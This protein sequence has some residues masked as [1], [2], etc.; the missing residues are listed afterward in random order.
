MVFFTTALLWFHYTSL[1]YNAGQFYI[2]WFVKIIMGFL[3]PLLDQKFNSNPI[4]LSAASE[5]PLPNGVEGT[6]TSAANGKTRLP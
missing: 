3:G 4:H 5:S 1:F 6:Y 2:I